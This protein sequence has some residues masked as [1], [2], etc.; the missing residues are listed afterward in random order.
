MRYKRKS[1]NINAI[2]Q[3]AYIVFDTIIVDD[4]AFL[5]NCTPL[6]WGSDSM[7]GL[8]HKAI[9]KLVGDGTYGFLSPPVINYL[10]FQVGAIIVVL[11]CYE[12]VTLVLLFHF[13]IINVSNLLFGFIGFRV[14]TCL[15]KSC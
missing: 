15:G 10:P 3:S 1:Y 2:K 12:F 8:R 14:A 11:Y 5:F 7:M 6:G 13:S 9:H 4:F